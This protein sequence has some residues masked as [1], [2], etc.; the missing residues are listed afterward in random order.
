MYEYLLV[1]CNR[2]VTFLRVLFAAMIEEASC[3][4]FPDF[5]EIFFV[6]VGTARDHRQFKAF[7][8]HEKLFANILGSFNSPSLDE[9]FIAP[10]VLIP[11]LF[12]CFINCE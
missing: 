11:V 8:N 3:D 10:G 4:G 7:H 2:L 5:A 6:N 1:V 9:I 12:P